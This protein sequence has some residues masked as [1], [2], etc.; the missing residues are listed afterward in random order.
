MALKGELEHFS[1]T[2]LFNL[3][4]L[5]RKTGTLFIEQE[6][7][8]AQISFR[9]GKLIYAQSGSQDGQLASMLHRAGKL[10]DDQVR[11]IRERA[12]TTSDKQLGL[13]LINAGYVSQADII[14]SIQ[15]Y[16]LDVV[17]DIL[18]WSRGRF[19]FEDN[20]MPPPDRITVPIDLEN[21]IIEYTR[22]MREVE[23]LEKELPNLDFALK[24][25]DRP[26]AS[27]RNINLSVEEWRVVSFI[28]PKNSIRQIA[29]ANEMSEMEIRQIVYGLLQAGLVELVRPPRKDDPQQSA[30]R[31]R[32]PTSQ[33]TPQVKKTVVNKLISRIKSL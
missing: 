25:P 12:G 8:Q 28:N 7:K 18:A 17:Y 27:L 31:R 13:L 20:R 29:K 30:A 9:E 10:S 16:T 15:Q 4:N 3:I 2:Q 1:T 23:H 11:L 32:R 22:N 26:G 14:Q 19:A 33:Q 5:A 24:F 6:G 21:V